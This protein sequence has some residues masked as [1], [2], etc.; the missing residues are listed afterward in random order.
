MLLWYTQLSKNKF[1]EIEIDHHDEWDWFEYRF[2]WTRKRD[3][4]GL[5]L[6]TELSRD[7]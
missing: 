1:F 2:S 5:E 3:H 6:Y 4:A 7:L